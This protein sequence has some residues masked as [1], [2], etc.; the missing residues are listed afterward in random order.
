MIGCIEHNKEMKNVGV[1]YVHSS[2]APA[3]SGV[4]QLV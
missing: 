2:H 4:C 1:L 3:P